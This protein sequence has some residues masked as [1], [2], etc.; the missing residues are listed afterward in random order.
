MRQIIFALASC[1]LVAAC[2][3]PV[4]PQA[5]VMPPAQPV[6]AEY[7]K[8]PPAASADNAPR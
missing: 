6:P 7:L 8:H 5:Y 2:A 1:A 3:A 4:P